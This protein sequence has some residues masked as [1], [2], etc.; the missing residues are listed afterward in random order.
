MVVPIKEYACAVNSRWHRGY[1][2]VLD[3]RLCLLSRLFLFSEPKRQLKR[4]SVVMLGS[5]SF[6]S[7]RLLRIHLPRQREANE[8][9]RPKVYAGNPSSEGG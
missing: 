1:L 2:F 5:A 4:M 6:L 7:L 8:K 3:E 9:C